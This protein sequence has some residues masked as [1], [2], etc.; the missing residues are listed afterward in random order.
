MTAGR[1]GGEQAAQLLMY[2]PK[3][4]YKCLQLNSFDKR[5][6]GGP[7]GPEQAAEVLLVEGVE[8]QR[9]ALEVPQLLMYSYYICLFL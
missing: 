5:C 9:R 1:A 6:D 2:G 8:E 4:L 7:G 3:K